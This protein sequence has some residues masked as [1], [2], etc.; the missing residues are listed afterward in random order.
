MR[1]LVRVLVT[2]VAT[3]GVLVGLAGDASS[4]AVGN[5][6]WYAWLENVATFAF[7]TARKGRRG[8]IDWKAY[9]Q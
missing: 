5:P 9:R 7:T 3:V 2:A 4:I 1:R 6:A 8:R